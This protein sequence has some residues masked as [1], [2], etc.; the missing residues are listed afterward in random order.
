MKT[1]PVF[2]LRSAFLRSDRHDLSN[3][4]ITAYSSI[5]DV[6]VLGN[7]SDD[8]NPFVRFD[9]SSATVSILNKMDFSFNWSSEN[10]V[11]S[12]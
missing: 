5:L 9:E 2:H 12:M 8:W 10:N 4:L 1:D 3:P 11:T 6:T 7:I